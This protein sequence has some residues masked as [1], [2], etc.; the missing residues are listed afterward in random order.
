MERYSVS[1]QSKCRKMQTIITPNMNTFHAV[2]FYQA[3]SFVL[4]RECLSTAYIS[5]DINDSQGFYFL[6]H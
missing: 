2:L 4:R 5:T 3:F 1:L 6:I